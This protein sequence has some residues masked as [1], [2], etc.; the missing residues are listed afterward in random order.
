MMMMP[1]VVPSS[2]AAAITSHH[3]HHGAGAPAGRRAAQRLIGRRQPPQLSNI[4]R[5]IEL[6]SQVYN[7]FF[8]IRKSSRAH[9]INTDCENYANSSSLRVA[10]CQ[11]EGGGILI[12]PLSSFLLSIKTRSAVRTTSCRHYSQRPHKTN[13]PPKDQQ[14]PYD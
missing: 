4:H 10:P 5:T 14:Y 7:L 9:N 1:V 13:P 2:P 3:H 8:L 11:R 6:Y 12:H